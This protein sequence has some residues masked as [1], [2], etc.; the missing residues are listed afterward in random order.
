MMFSSGWA[1]GV[2]FDVYRVVSRTL[3]LSRWIMAV[4]D[5]VYWIAATL[6]VFKILYY[7]NQG[8]V[9]FFVFLGLLLGTV[10]YFYF[11]SSYTVI[12]VK[13]VLKLLENL[14][15]IVVR[16][17]ELLIVRPI[18]LLYKLFIIL[19]GILTAIAMFLFKIMVQLFYPLWFVTRGLGQWLSK[20]FSWPSWL[21]QTVKWCKRT[22]KRFF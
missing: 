7:S 13:L 12:A 2:L 1:L 10:F 17:I 3:H 20:T 5:L 9:R 21:R 11:I 8:E 4:L 19:L 15:D 16:C 22:F 18:L 6:F 14:Y